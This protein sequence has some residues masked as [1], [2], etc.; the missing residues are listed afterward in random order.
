MSVTSPAAVS[1]SLAFMSERTI[2]PFLGIGGF[3]RVPST[4]SSPL[5][6]PPTVILPVGST[7]SLSRSRMSGFFEAAVTVFHTTSTSSPTLAVAGA[8]TSAVVVPWT[9]GS[10][11]IGGGRHSV[12]YDT[13]AARA[14]AVPSS[15]LAPPTSSATAAAP[16]L[17]SVSALRSLLT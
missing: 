2:A 16:V 9:G 11:E 4:A 12:W 10:P 3:C 14:G 7:V 6:A 5:C 13:S 17:R 1:F 8:R 15:T